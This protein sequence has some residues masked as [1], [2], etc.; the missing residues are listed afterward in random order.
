MNPEK[1]HS[2]VST[3]L[4]I[5][6]VLCNVL[7][8]DLKKNKGIIINISSVTAKYISTYGCAYA[9]TKAG[10]THFSESLFQKSEK[11]E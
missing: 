10:L 11:L 7:L 4:E 1:I 6:M 8:R 3:N 5:P 2:M 9:A